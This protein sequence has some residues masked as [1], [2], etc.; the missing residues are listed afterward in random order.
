MLDIGCLGV[1]AYQTKNV[2]SNF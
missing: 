2:F 1:T